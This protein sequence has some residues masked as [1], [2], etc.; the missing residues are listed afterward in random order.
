VLSKKKKKHKSRRL[1]NFLKQ[2]KIESHTHRAS[3]VLMGMSVIDA[4]I[5]KQN[6]TE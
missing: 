4:H 3:A 1:E 2:I 5:K 6:K